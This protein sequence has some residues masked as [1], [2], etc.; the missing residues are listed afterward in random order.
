MYDPHLDTFLIVANTGSF[1]GAAEYLYITPSA[2]IQQINALEAKLKVPLFYR[3]NK[4]VSLTKQGAYLK[5]ECMDYIK[6]GKAIQEQLR[7]MPDG[8]LSLVLGT[9]LR[10]KC[11][12][13]YDFWVQFSQGR[14]QYSVQMKTIDTRFPITSEVDFIESISTNASWH[15]AWEYYELCHVPYGLAMAKDHP[16]YE[17]PSLCY[18]DLRDYSVIVQRPE[19]NWKNIDRVKEDLSGNG[20]RIQERRGFDS[21]VVWDAS[22][23][24]YLIV[25]PLCLRDVIFDMRI[26]PMSWEHSVSYGLFYRPE[27]AGLPKLFLDFVR[28]YHSTHPGITARLTDID[29]AKKGI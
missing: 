27:P 5:S 22:I 1:S 18:D 6:K 29:F 15:S 12:V 8:E 14:E 26:A 2:V 11:R 16:L 9:S 23:K 4:G 20:I 28:G 19:E 10:E 21:D 17:K 3:S 13:F 24:R 7:S 25:M